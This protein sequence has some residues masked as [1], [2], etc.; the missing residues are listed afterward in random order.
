LSDHLAF[1]G[2]A[3]A[4]RNELPINNVIVVTVPAINRNRE[5][6]MPEALDTAVHELAHLYRPIREEDGKTLATLIAKD[7]V[8]VSSFRESL[9]QALDDESLDTATKTQMQQL[10]RAYSNVA[11]QL[12]VFME[13]EPIFGAEQKKEQRA[14]LKYKKRVNEGY[15]TPEKKYAEI[16]A[17]I[18]AMQHRYGALVKTLAPNLS[19][20]SQ[21]K[22]V[23]GNAFTHVERITRPLPASGLGV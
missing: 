15:P 10:H 14:F 11:S 23:S 2:A 7:Q 3:I 12:A 17:R 5:L 1:A 4:K 18:A 8:Y 21:D 13:A 16:P 22:T 19:R 20:W 9:Q 6:L